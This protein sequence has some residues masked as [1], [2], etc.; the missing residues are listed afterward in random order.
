MN[1]ATGSPA[2]EN[3]LAVGDLIIG[4]NGWKADKNYNVHINQIEGHQTSFLIS[5]GSR[6][7]TIEMMPTVKNYFSTWKVKHISEKNSAQE[8]FFNQWAKNL[9]THYKQRSL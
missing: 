2:F 1:V 6:I 3:G 8:Q 7:K 9:R 4:V 5:R